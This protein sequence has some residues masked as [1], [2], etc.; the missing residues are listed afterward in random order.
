MKLFKTLYQLSAVTVI[1]LTVASCVDMDQF[2]ED[3]VSPDNFFTSSKELELYTNSFYGMLPSAEGVYNEE[4]DNIIKTD[5]AV[6]LEGGQRRIVPASGGGWSWGNLR[7]INYYLQNSSRCKDAQARAR[8]DAVARFFR[9][10]F[11]FDKVKRFGDVP[12]YSTTLSYT[13]WDKMREPRTPRTQV[14]DSI[15]ADIDYAIKNLPTAKSVNAINKW[16]ALALKS[17]IC[18]FEG[19]FRKYHTELKLPESGKYLDLAVQSSS[20]IMNSGQYKIYNTGN[21]N[22]DYQNLFASAT[23]NEDEYILARS[24]SDGLQ[25]YNNL[26]YYTMTASYGRPGLEKRLVN[27]YLMKDGSRFTDK[28]G[29]DKMQFYEET[30]NRDP[31][32]SQ[33]IR[34]PGYTRIGNNV[35]LVPTFGAT[36]TGYQLIKYV[37]GEQYDTY[38]KSIVAVPIFRYAEVL[39]NYAEAKAEAGTLTQDDIDKSIKLLR[40][41]AGMPDLNMAAANADPDP[42]QSNLYKYVIGPNKGVILEIRRERR[43]ELVMEN[44]RWDDILRWKAGSTLTEQFKGMYFPAPGY[45]DLDHDGKNDVCLYEGDKPEN[46]K[47]VQYL[48]LGGD[49][50]LENKTSGNIVVRPDVKK[51]WDENRDY[52]YPIPINE[53]SLNNNLKQNPGW[54]DG[55]N[56]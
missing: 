55:L 47:N 44:F 51:V 22:A 11:Y 36:V 20:E 38:A 33:T 19:T 32:L 21:P 34:T 15:M 49:V 6:E 46:E 24:F 13:D 1:G 2:P 30:Q 3:A 42:Y 29:Y 40:D 37:M 17:R 45:Y 25:V 26:N 18:L 7:N 53:R 56:F 5:L 43:I 48:K 27:S 54:D 12:W 8:Y 28:P 52:F 39:L 16:T 9:A 41:R 35:K 14:V 31:R 4:V 50:I 10:Y 23:P